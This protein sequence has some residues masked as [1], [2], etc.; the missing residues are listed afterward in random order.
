[1]DIAAIWSDFEIAVFHFPLGRTVFF[2]E[3]LREI[4]PVEENNG[5]R[6]WFAWSVLSAGGTGSDD[7]RN[8]TIEVVNFPFGVNLGKTR[9]S[10]QQ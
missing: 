7:G 3:P 10:K 2:V 5:V 4:F 9:R 1:M 8:G 6:G